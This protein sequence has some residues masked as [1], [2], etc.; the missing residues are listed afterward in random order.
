MPIP[1]WLRIRRESPPQAQDA[2][3][4]V[5]CPSC[6]EM[7][8]RKDLEANASVCSRCQHHFRMHAYDRINLL[9]DRDFVEVGGNLVPGD[10]LGWVDKRPYPQKLE[11]D[12]QKSHLSEAVVTGFCTIGGFP[13]ALAVVVF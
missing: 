7:L 4:W 12:R 9:V 1:D 11:T 13:L 6:G 8:Y 2:A 10:P 5:K 3:L